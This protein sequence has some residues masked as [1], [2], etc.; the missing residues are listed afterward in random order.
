MFILLGNI[1]A[2]TQ[3]QVS[4]PINLAHLAARP[5]APC[6]IGT[7]CDPTYPWQTFNDLDGMF[8]SSTSTVAA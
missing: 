2:I 8:A 7:R 6:E 3:L 4:A 5:S 1:F